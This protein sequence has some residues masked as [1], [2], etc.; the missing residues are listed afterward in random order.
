M[1]RGA[2]VD[3]PVEGLGVSYVLYGQRFV[4]FTVEY[5]EFVVPDCAELTFFV[6]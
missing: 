3:A 4:L 2:F 1:I 6:G 5:G